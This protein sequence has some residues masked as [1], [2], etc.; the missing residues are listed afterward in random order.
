MLASG[1]LLTNGQGLSEKD[2]VEKG[3]IIDSVL[4]ADGKESFALYVP[5]GLE[6]QKERQK[7]HPLILIFDPMAR[8]AIGIKPFVLAAEIHG[9][10]L[11]CSNDSRNGPYA[12]NMEVAD[13]MFEQIQ[14]MFDLD[15]KR[16]YT[17]GFSG[18]SRLASRIAL[19]N[20]SIKGVI[21]CGA[22]FPE[23][24]EYQLLTNRFHYAAVIG[25]R[26]MNFLEFQDLKRI[27]AKTS[28]PHEVITVDLDH[29]WPSP[30]SIL[31]ATDWLQMQYFKEYPDKRS[32][33]LIRQAYERAYTDL[34][35]HERQGH[36]VEGAEGYD[37]LLGNYRRYLDL[38]SIRSKREVLV[39]SKDYRAQKRIFEA[40]LEEERQL[41]IEFWDRF[42]RDLEDPGTDLK[43]WKKRLEKLDAKPDN[44]QRLNENMH[45]RLKY[46]IFA[47]ALE[48][49]QFRT[50]PDAHAQKE[51]C[52]ELCRLI[53]PGYSF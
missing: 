46:K 32:E 5:E 42:N 50:L 25:N 34:V 41:T 31:M 35:S 11:A 7:K 40:S 28:F 16:I 18:G 29:R 8:G 9:Y 12:P 49:A 6:S 52:Y 45:E 19:G 24:A 33:S 21:A 13:R 1:T 44:R 14:S 43:W 39:G 22:G 36:L 38:D 3:K 51:F 4:T 10:L 23:G 26:D 30:E 37:R 20:T 17:S 27:L 48:T 15:E 2:G 53:Y 47:H